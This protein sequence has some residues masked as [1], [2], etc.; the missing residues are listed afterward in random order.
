MGSSLRH[1]VQDLK[2]IVTTYHNNEA[3]PNLEEMVNKIK[4]KKYE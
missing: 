3:I 4:E 2:I 1:A